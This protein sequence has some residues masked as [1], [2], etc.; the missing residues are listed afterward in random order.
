MEKNPHHLSRNPPCSSG[1]CCLSVLIRYPQNHPHLLPEEVLHPQMYPFPLLP[2]SVRPAFPVW[3]IHL[4]F[5]PALLLHLQSSLTPGSSQDVC[6][7]LLPKQS[8]HPVS[9]SALSYPYCSLP[10]FKSLSLICFRFFALL[11]YP[12]LCARNLTGT[13]KLPHR[14]IPL[15]LQGLVQ[16]KKFKCGSRNTV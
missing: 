9:S 1:I 15:N 6:H 2:E 3:H 8:V 11:I 7:E 13:E 5:P 4:P 10:C 14:L 16:S 12:F